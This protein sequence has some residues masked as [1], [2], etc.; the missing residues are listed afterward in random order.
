MNT[1][2]MFSSKSDN[3]ATPQEFFD[4][5]NDEFHFELDVCAT[6]QNAKCSKYFTPEQDGLA[7]EW[8]G[9]L[10]DEPSLWQRNR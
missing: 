4:K 1:D 5:L 2:L 3:W 10:L 7:Q 6:P 9:A 8:G